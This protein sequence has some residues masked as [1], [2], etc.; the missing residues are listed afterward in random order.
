MADDKGRN[1]HGG[2]DDQDN[3][4]D[5][6]GTADSGDSDFESGDSG[7]GNLPPLSDFESSAGGGFDSGLPP[8]SSID[9]DDSGHSA[10]GLPPISDIPVETPQPTGGAIRPP[11]PE[12]GSTPVFGT[13]SSDSG[14][15]TPSGTGFQDLSADSDFTPETPEVAPP[16]PESDIDTPLFDSAFGGSGGFSAAADT[17]APTQAMETPMFGA[18]Q[19]QGFDADAFGSGGGRGFDQGTPVPDFGPDTAAPTAMTPPPAPQAAAKSGKGGGGKGI[20]IG[21]AAL[22]LGLIGGIFAGPYVPGM[23][24]PAATEAE[25]LRGEVTRLQAQNRELQGRTTE[26][27]LSEETINEL[28]AQEAEL[29]AQIAE[30]SAQLETAQAEYTTVSAELDSAKAELEATNAD[31]V[32]AQDD[33]ERLVN[34][35]AITRARK[36]GLEAEVTRLEGLT[37]QLEDANTRRMI[38][39]ETLESNIERL[40]ILVSEASPLAPE[41]YSRESRMAAV[42]NLKQRAQGMNWVDSQLLDAY[43]ALYVQELEIARSREYFFA[44]LPV[45]D[46]FGTTTMS[47]AECVMNGNWGVYYRTLDGEHVGVYQSTSA[48]GSPDYQFLDIRDEAARSNVEA[49]IFASRTEGF[50]EKL[51]LLAKKQ[52]VVDDRTPFQK[53]FESL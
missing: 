1:Q 4:T 13:P 39:K 16:G 41:K 14:L 5:G 52:L 48:L 8:L 15:D 37:G 33:F 44:R 45:T 43:T 51:E 3:E 42:A 29:E 31:F 34:E 10:G 32:Q 24:N 35:T 18:D 40:E 27:P 38:T 9:S 20:L 46:R 47:W 21:I 49:Q 17:S 53:S 11:A 25:Q 7:L 23:P 12:Y 2:S 22:I 30:S 28:R 26:A 50:E 19:N 6:F 36:D